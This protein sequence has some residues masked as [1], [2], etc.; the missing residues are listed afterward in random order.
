MGMVG[1][2][3]GA[4]IGQV[5]RIAAA[6]D[7][8]IDLVCGAFGSNA[9]NSRDMGKELMLSED[10]VYPDYKSMIAGEKELPNGD[11]MDF[12]SV[13][14]PNHVHYD[15]A[16]MSL[17]NGF[18]VMIDKPIAFSYEEA[19]KL[20]DIVNETGLFLGLTHT[21]TGYPMVKEARQLIKSGMFGKI[22]KAYVEYP[23]GWLS[24]RLE[25]SDQKQAAWRTDPSRSGKG[26]ASGDIGTHA[27][28]LVEYVTGLHISQICGGLH[29]YVEGRSL[30]DDCEILLQF[31]N[32]ATGTLFATQV[33]AGEENKIKFR[34]YGE[35][36]GVE[37]NQEDANS[38]KVKM[39]DNPSAEFRGGSP[40]VAACANPLEISCR[41]RLFLN[42]GPPFPASA[43]STSFPSIWPQPCFDV[44][45][46]RDHRDRQVGLSCFFRPLPTT[47]P[48]RSG[49]A[50]AV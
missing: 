20:K 35:N 17:Q 5:H 7:S 43:I 47:A 4:F 29:T 44:K 50:V 46:L 33:A 27:E 36:G 38:L 37:W 11:R 21:Y 18:H 24:T 19:L 10:R 8:Q 48:V 49:Q 42:G 45:S 23:Q 28:N 14:T 30:D 6:M 13:V 15:P 9:D 32:G 16:A 22:R 1:G 34:V 26:G 41:T 2:G 12:V 39:L 3:P 40:S 25:A 31:E